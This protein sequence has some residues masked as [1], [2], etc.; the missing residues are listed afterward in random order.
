LLGSG[1]N[2]LFREQFLELTQRCELRST[3]EN[4]SANSNRSRHFLKRGISDGKK[5]E[6]ERDCPFMGKRNKPKE[7]IWTNLEVSGA[8]D[9]LVSPVGE[10]GIPLG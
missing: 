4:F 6:I 9:D 3:V 2:V 8:V 5:A 1:I 10:A 7:R